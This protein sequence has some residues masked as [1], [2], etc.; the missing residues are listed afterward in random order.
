MRLGAATSR[1]GKKPLLVPLLLLALSS[2]L[3]CATA[4]TN[5]VP[6]P[7]K[8]ACG[9]LVAAINNLA[10]T[11]ATQLE[12]VGGS[13]KAEIFSP[14]SIGTMMFLLLRAANSSLRN[15]LLKILQLD[16]FREGNTTSQITKNFGHLLKEFTHDIAGKGILDELPA[17]QGKQSCY[18]GD[19]GNFD[20]YDD[21]EFLPEPV[22]PNV[23]Q[24][25]NGMFVQDGFLP[26]STDFV[27]L[28]RTL[29]HARIERVNFREQPEATRSTINRWVSEST[30]GRIAEILAD[31]LPRGTQMVLASALYFKATWETF[32][33][34]PQYTRP[35]PFFPDGEDQ[36]PVQVPTMFT[37]GCFPYHAS[38]ELDASIMAFPYRNRTTSMYIILPNA[39]NRAKVRALRAK[40]DSA[41]LD[42]L[43]GQMKR[44][45]ATVVFPRLHLNNRY[46]LR[47]ALEQLGLQALFDP[48]KNNLKFG[49]PV[50]K[51]AKKLYVDSMVHQIDLEVN[52]HG[53]EGGAVTMT[54]MERSLPPVNFRVRGPFLIAIRHDP[55]K[56]L[57]FYGA[58]YDPS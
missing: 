56:M 6:P 24:L 35:Q 32:F 36:P 43:I 12:S 17:W 8:A 45:K 3:W 55:T 21:D 40:L 14:V 4:A 57:L 33:N 15:E 31:S 2:V 52:E 27:R 50:G 9:Q 51:G 30:R 54:A 19:A 28:A 23:V 25:A 29:Y 13:P 37:G 22:Q 26:N 5:S 53:T 11:L 41:T 49:Q 7:T 48:R 38:P 58:V 34:D 16:Q 18:P 46:N 39:S 10:R 44:Q 1:A 47:S 20:E 42:R